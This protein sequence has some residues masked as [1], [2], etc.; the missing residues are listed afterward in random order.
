MENIQEKDQLDPKDIKFGL[1]AIDPEEEG[2]MKTIL[3]F[4]GYWKQPTLVE[5]EELRKELSEDTEFGLTEIAH[6]LEIFPAPEEIL[7]QFLE[8]INQNL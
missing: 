4:C 2:D 6:R 8:D 1:I 5:A 7:G 3:H